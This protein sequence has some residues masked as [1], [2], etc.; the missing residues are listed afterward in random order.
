MLAYRPGVASWTEL[1]SS[2][3]LGATTS[4]VESFGLLSNGAGFQEI[5]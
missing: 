1:H 3:S 5:I 2:S 4:I